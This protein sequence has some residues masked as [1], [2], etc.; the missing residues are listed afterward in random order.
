M[1]CVLYVGVRLLW[2]VLFIVC[3]VCC[4][5]YDFGCDSL[6]VDGCRLCVVC[7][8][9]FVVCCLNCVRCAV[10]VVRLVWFEGCLAFS[11]C[12][13]LIVARRVLCV[14]VWLCFVVCC[15]ICGL[16]IVVRC[17]RWVG[18]VLVV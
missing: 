7:C 9:L 8:V 12:W 10:C 18:L 5:V 14:V 6:F 3:G 17:S 16:L 11:V 1:C 4:A 13:L 2:I 15:V